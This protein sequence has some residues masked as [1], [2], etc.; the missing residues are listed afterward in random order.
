MNIIEELKQFNWTN[1]SENEI[2]TM[3]Y[4]IEN[5]EGELTEEEKVELSDYLNEL[6]DMIKNERNVDF[7]NNELAYIQK[8]KE[9]NSSSDEE[10]TSR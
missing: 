9:E 4:N 3:I 7:A 2:N 8:V 6:E 10:N 1:P 5:Y